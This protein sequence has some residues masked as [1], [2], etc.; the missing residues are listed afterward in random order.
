MALHTG[1]LHF[2]TNEIKSYTHL[3]WLYTYYRNL[4]KFHICLLLLLSWLQEPCLQMYLFI[5]I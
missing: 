2:L 3:H 5:I 4:F 1:F